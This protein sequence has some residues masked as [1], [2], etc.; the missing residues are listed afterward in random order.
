MHEKRYGHRLAIDVELV[1]LRALVSAAG[2][3]FT[4]TAD[5]RA[6]DSQSMISNDSGSIVPRIALKS[7]EIITGPAIVTETV[8]TT[9][10]AEGWRC[11]VD[12]VGNLLLSRG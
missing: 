10:I 3:D 9:W 11:E 6:T 7:G 4:L 8:A 1:N 12:K 2:I 5:V